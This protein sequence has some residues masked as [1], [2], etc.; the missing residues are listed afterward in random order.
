MINKKTKINLPKTNLFLPKTIRIYFQTDREPIFN[1]LDNI[2]SLTQPIHPFFQ[3][4]HSFPNCKRG[5]GRYTFREMKDW[6]NIKHTF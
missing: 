5:F 6:N 1:Y 3:F 2:F 4:H